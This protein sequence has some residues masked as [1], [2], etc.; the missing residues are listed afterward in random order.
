VRESG[1]TG[2]STLDVGG[3]KSLAVDEWADVE[4]SGENWVLTGYGGL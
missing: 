4:Y 1:A 2:G 3:L